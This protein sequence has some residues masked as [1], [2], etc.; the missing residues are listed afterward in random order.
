MGPKPDAVNARPKPDVVGRPLVHSSPCHRGRVK[1]AGGLPAK[2]GMTRQSCG[3]G[4]RVGRPLVI[5]RLA[6]ESKANGSSLNPLSMVPSG[7]AKLNGPECRLSS[8]STCA[9]LGIVHLSWDMSRT[10]VRR[11][12]HLS[13]YDPKVEGE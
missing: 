1:A 7:V 8:G 9:R 6:M 11:S 10:R 13:F 4:G 12:R 5:A 3:V 2:V